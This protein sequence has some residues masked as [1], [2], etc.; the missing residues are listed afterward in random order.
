MEILRKLRQSGLLDVEAYHLSPEDGGFTECIAGL[1]SAALAK[2]DQPGWASDFLVGIIGTPYCPES[3]LNGRSHVHDAR[4]ASDFTAHVDRRLSDDSDLPRYTMKMNEVVDA[5]G[6]R[7]QYTFETISLVP[8]EF[9]AT[10]QFGDSVYKGKASTKKEAKH[11]ASK[12]ACLDKGF[13]A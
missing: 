8:P 4:S 11:L 13:L 7:A 10:L 2:M 3:G 12:N 5:Q 9:E 1:G 6:C